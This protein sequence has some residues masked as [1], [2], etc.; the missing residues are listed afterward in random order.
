MTFSAK[1][2]ESFTAFE[3]SGWEKAA[4]AYHDHWGALSAQ[5]AI[6]ML[7][8]AEVRHGARS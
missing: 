2:I 1:D 7:D 6:P 3:K 8:L 5:S 4:E